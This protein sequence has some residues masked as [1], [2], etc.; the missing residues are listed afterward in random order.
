MFIGLSVSIPLGA[1]FLAGA[2]VGG[3]VT[4][5]TKKCQKETHKSYDIG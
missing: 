1:V 2:S 5:L 3:V 4:A